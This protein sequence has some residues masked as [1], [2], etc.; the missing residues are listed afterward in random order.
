LVEDVLTSSDLVG[1]PY[2]AIYEGVNQAF[3]A[4][5]PQGNTGTLLLLVEP[6]TEF[7]STASGAQKLLASYFPG[8][9]GIPYVAVT[10][11][12]NAYT[13]QAASGGSSFIVLGF[14]RFEGV[15]VAFLSV[16]TDLYVGT[17][18]KAKD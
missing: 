1:A 12:G 5:A 17:A 8:A 7:P 6:K 3:W 15:P 2:R 9:A 14:V 13:F 4:E 11:N 16:G 18:V 10:E